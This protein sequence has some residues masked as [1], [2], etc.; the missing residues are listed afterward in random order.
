MSDTIIRRVAVALNSSRPIIG[1]AEMTRCPR[2][3]ARSWT[4]G[5]RRPPIAILKLL[6]HELR[7][8]QEE[9]LALIPE[10]DHIVMKREHEPRHRTGFCM[11]DPTTGLDK[12]NK[13][14]RPRRKIS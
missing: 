5:H 9:L 14:G 2:A 10:L 13:S 1:L 11:I 12:R 3:T 8:R 4:S 6:Q 7:R